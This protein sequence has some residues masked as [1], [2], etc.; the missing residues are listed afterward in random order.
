M[1]TP[2]AIESEPTSTASAQGTDEKTIAGFG[3][4]WT[5]YTENEGYYGSV[6]CLK[7]I[8]GPLLDFTAVE[9]KD[10]AEIGSGSGRIVNMLLDVGAKSVVAVEP[11]EA[12]EVLTENT[13]NR[14]DRVRLVHG[15]GESIADFSN[16]DLVVS[17]GVLHHIVDPNPVVASAY[18]ALRPGGKMLIWL[19]GCEGNELYLSLATPMRAVTTR[20]PHALLSVLSHLLCVALNI[21]VYLCQFVPLPMRSYMQNHI[22]KLDYSQRQLTIYDQLNPAYAKYYPQSQARQLLERH[23]FKNVALFHRHG[24]SWTV[25]GEKI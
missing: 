23:G 11:S 8:F 22:A 4:Q 20:L 25:V 3:R 15:R 6:D 21:Y 12:F 13:I 16:L 10:V 18:S 14:K 7:D 24:Y 2:N 5:A 19:Y 9:G 1:P 17:I